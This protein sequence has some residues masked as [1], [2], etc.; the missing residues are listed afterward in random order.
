MPAGVNIKPEKSHQLAIGLSKAFSELNFSEEAYY[1]TIQSLIDYDDHA[2]M[3][4][5]PYIE[6]ELRFGKGYAYGFEFMLQKQKGIF[7]FYTA[8]TYSR[9]FATINDVNNGNPFPAR[10]DKPHNINLNISYKK[11]K[12]WD[13]SANWVYASGMRFSSPTGFY[14][15]KGYNIPIYSEK[16]NDNLP[17]YH[18]LDISA[19]L[20]LN[21]KESARYKHDFTFSIFNFYGRNNIIALNFNKVE[22]ETGSFQVPT[23][24]VSEQ[25]IIPTSISL[26]GFMPSIA[27]SFKYR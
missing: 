22:T 13:F 12:R 8:Y 19:K 23:N 2:N 21:T 16:N 5:N 18:R 25:D 26:L 4:L 9:V 11:G 24:L 10:H 3:L 1:K 20:N 17:D 27:Y 15:Y 7:N 6:G 14:N